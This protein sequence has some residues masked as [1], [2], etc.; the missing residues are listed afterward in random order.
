[1]KVVLDFVFMFPS[2]FEDALGVMFEL[3]AYESETWF[4]GAVELCF[5]KVGDL[6]S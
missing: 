2:A 1:M 3:E 5:V 6:F 4:L